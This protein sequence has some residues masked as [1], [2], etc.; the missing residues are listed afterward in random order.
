MYLSPLKHVWAL[1]FKL[2][3]I[4]KT[5]AGASESYVILYVN[6]YAQQVCFLVDVI[7]RIRVN[8]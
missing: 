3:F 1:F 6:I 8:F 7:D 5:Y 2:Y 4:E